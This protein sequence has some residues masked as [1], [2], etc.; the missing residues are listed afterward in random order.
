VSGGDV[1]LSGLPL[2]QRRVGM[3]VDILR[4][5]LELLSDRDIANDERMLNRE[6]FR[7]IMD[8]YAE[9]SRHSLEVPDFAPVCDA[10]NPASEP[11]PTVAERKK[12]DFRW[13]LVDHQAGVGIALVPF[14]VECKR[15]GSPTASGFRFNREYVV[16]GIIR[17]VDTDYRYGENAASG[18]MV[19]YW[20]DM[21]Y[22]KI[23]SEVNSYIHAAGLPRLEAG[24]GKLRESEHSFARAFLQSP[25]SLRHLWLDMTSDKSSD[26]I[27][28]GTQHGRQASTGI[29]SSGAAVGVP[30]PAREVPES[31]QGHEAE[32]SA[33]PRS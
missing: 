16:S 13:D 5:G 1:I 27:T 24:Q 11:E 8:T 22:E 6:L 23:L 26:V 28:S 4:R 14:A 15:L 18:A 31:V 9:R 21:Q 30:M 7:C 2:W 17:F 32:R 12:P 10:P 20:Q 3:L 33:P 19:G 25:F 29:A